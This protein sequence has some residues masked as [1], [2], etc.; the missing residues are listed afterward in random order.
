VIAGDVAGHAGPGA[1]HTPIT[2][3][4]I[5]VDPG[6]RVDL[7]WHPDYNALVYALAGAGTVGPE[8]RPIRAGQLA[9]LGEGDAV[10]VSADRSQDS[11]T[12]KL[13]LYVMG[14]RPI[15]EPV[16]HYGPFVMNT[17]DE[18]V[19]AFEDYRLGRLG[20]IPAERVPHTG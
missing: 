15:R 1:T 5:T 11:H 18:L 17:R 16:A 4:H 14:G 12:P 10:R 20:V 6:A 19:Q 9:V 8:Q 13:E 2:L 3:V 7:P